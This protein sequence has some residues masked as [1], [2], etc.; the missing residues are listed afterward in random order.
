MLPKLIKSQ[1]LTKSVTESV[2]ESITN[3][4]NESLPKTLAKSSTL[5]LT[6]VRSTP[7]LLAYKGI[8]VRHLELFN[9]IVEHHT[10]HKAAEILQVTQPA[11]SKSIA[12]LEN[13]LGV[14]LFTRT[15][16]GMWLTSYGEVLKRHAATFMSNLAEMAREIRQMHQGA[17]GLIRLGFV[18]SL[19]PEL[20]STLISEAL[21][22]FPEIQIRTV[23]GPTNQLLASMDRNELDLILGRILDVQIAKFYKVLPVYRESFAIVCS[24]KNKQ[25]SSNA[26]DW[27]T[28]SNGR[29]ILPA[30]QTPFRE[31]IDHL[32]TQQNVLRPNV[33]VES[34]SF[35]KVQKL[36]NNTD[37]LG[38]LPTSL[39]LQGQ[40]DG[41]LKVLKPNLG[42]NFAP[43]SLI[44]RKETEMAPLTQNFVKLIS[45][46]NIEQ[47]H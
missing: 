40:K 11:A 33:V 14:E 28:L 23:E 2:T 12:E 29:W 24:I 3:F 21:A 20:L 10:L 39:A 37:L 36:I 25:M 41:T 18:P 22:K 32:F 38:I 16:K 27:A 42:K 5:E 45:T 44:Y 34:S 15:K 7:H 1:S 47:C 9:A 8:K 43:I 13:I 26:I 6:K 30:M 46:L 31:M 35:E 19:D 4:Q 17:V